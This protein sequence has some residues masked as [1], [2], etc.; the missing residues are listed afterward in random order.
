MELAAHHQRDLF[1]FYLFF[2]L[3]FCPPGTFGTLARCWLPA[4]PAQVLCAWERSKNGSR[5]RLLLARPVVP[6][7]VCLSAR[8]SANDQTKCL[9]VP[10]VLCRGGSRRG[11]SRYLRPPPHLPRSVPGRRAGREV[12]THVPFFFAVFLLLQVPV[13]ACTWPAWPGLTFRRGWRRIARTHARSLV[14]RRSSLLYSSQPTLARKHLLS[15]IFFARIQLR[16]SFF[17]FCFSNRNAGFALLLTP[18]SLLDDV[19]HY[20]PAIL[21]TVSLRLTNHAQRTLHHARHYTTTDTTL[22]CARRHTPKPLRYL[23][24]F[25]PFHPSPT[26][27]PSFDIRRIHYPTNKII[28]RQLATRLRQT[29]NSNNKYPGTFSR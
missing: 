20:Q 1:R 15:F 22:V 25:A 11:P 9:C 14:A 2:F 29:P 21:S 16:Q 6:V 13:C 28:V 24:G 26:I 4:L 12:R 8:A 23:P 17:F 10:V 27:L 18:V 3:F 7:S 5:C 19:N